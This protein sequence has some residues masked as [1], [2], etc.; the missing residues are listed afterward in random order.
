MCQGFSADCLT[1]AFF[2]TNLVIAFSAAG[3]GS[4]VLLAGFFLRPSTV[5]LLSGGFAWLS[6]GIGTITR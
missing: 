6:S 4:I 1:V 5:R 3:N 2:D